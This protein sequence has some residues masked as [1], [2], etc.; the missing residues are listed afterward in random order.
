MVRVFCPTVYVLCVLSVVTVTA[1]ANVSLYID[2]FLSNSE[3]CQYI[4]IVVIS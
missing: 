4:N 3:A 1:C 2:V